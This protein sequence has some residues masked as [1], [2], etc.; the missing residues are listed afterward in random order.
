MVT[1]SISG[2][3]Y[4]DGVEVG[5]FTIYYE[6]EA[7]NALTE[8][9]VSKT[10]NVDVLINSTNVGSGVVNYDDYITYDEG[11]TRSYQIIGDI[12]INTSNVGSIT[13]QMSDDYGKI[14]KATQI[15]LQIIPQ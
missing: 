9:I 15:T 7:V 10:T 6:D 13:L 12:L 5:N 3:V 1:K 8:N 14:K 2:T 11:G 4:I